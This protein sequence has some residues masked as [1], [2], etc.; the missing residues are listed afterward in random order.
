MPSLVPV[1]A[2]SFTGQRPLKTNYTAIRYLPTVL[3]ILRILALPLPFPLA[4][5][6]CTSIH[7]SDK[8]LIYVAGDLARAQHAHGLKLNY[9][10]SVA[11]ITAHLLELARDG[12]SVAELMSA[13]RNVLSRADVMEGSQGNDPGNPGRSDFS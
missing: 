1:M 5:P 9:P 6:P 2:S 7:K 3:M 8:L 12:Q 10:E 4:R 13:G 11:L